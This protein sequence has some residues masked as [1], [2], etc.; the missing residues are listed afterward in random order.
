MLYRKDKFSRKALEKWKVNSIEIL[1]KNL[2]GPGT[3]VYSLTLRRCL[4]AN[5][6]F[7]RYYPVSISF[8]IPTQQ[9]EQLF[10]LIPCKTETTLLGLSILQGEGSSLLR[11]VRNHQLSNA[12]SHSRRLESSLRKQTNAMPQAGWTPRLPAPYKAQTQ[13]TKL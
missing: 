11:N 12:M 9:E 2:F 13:Y 8:Q 10:N 3:N 5:G 7:C 1:G 6:W 4:Q